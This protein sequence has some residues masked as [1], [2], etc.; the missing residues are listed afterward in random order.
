MFVLLPLFILWRHT[1]TLIP[2]VMIIKLNQ[3]YFVLLY[4]MYR[5]YS[6]NIPINVHVQ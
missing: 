5:Q 4:L 6:D 2:I 3:F 1:L